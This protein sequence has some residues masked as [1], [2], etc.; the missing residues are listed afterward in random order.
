MNKIQYI[1]ALPDAF[2]KGITSNNY[3]LLLVPEIAT[4]E[5]KNDIAVC[6][7]QLDIQ[8]ATGGTLDLYGTIYDV[9]RGTMN[10]NQYR[11]YI[12]NTALANRSDGTIDNLL[13]CLETIF[14]T[15]MSVTEGTGKV[16]INN[17]TEDAVERSGFTLNQIADLVNSLLAVGVS[18][19]AIETDYGE[20]TF[21]FGSVA[22]G[23]NGEY[24][25]LSGLS[26]VND[27]EI[28][29]RLAGFYKI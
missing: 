29:G 21:T 26:S 13:D 24:N 8:Q 11:T 15:K 25:E 20:N 16:I 14:Q 4:S 7:N 23:E 12:L 10:D 9:S 3:K 17:L 18:V 22:D 19:E 28:G 2:T 6:S 27:A 1:E 5:F